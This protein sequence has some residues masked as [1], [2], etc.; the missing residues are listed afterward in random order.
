M[1]A[2]TIAQR[3]ARRRNHTTRYRAGKVWNRSRAMPRGTCALI[4]E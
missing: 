4:L 3:R 2:R 1:G